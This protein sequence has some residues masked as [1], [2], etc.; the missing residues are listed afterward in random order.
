[1]FWDGRVKTLEEQ[2][3]KV[4]TNPVEFGNTP[5]QL[6]HRLETSRLHRLL[7][8]RAFGTE[9]ITLEG[10]AQAIA[11]F[12]Q[13]LQVNENDMAAQIYM[14]RCEELITKILPEDW[15]PVRDLAF[16]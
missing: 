16:K 7:Y 9:Q 13:V 4:V 12:E 6:I 8:L 10:V 1:M 14:N 5:E 15:S 2:V 11:C 3:F